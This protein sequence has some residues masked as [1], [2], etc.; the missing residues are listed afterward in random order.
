MAIFSR[1]DFDASQV[2]PTT[3]VLDGQGVRVVG[4][5]NT[6]AHL[7]DVNGDGLDDLVVQI[8]DVDGTYEAGEAIAI[9]SGVTFGG[10]QIQGTDTLCIN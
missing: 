3:V 5:G 1:A 6:Q 9:L 10:T 7:E 8:E 4:Q 2:D